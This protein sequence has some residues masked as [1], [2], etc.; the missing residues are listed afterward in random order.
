MIKESLPIWNPTCASGANRNTIF[1]IQC[2]YRHDRHESV[3]SSGSAI[4]DTTKV[5]PVADF[6]WERAKRLGLT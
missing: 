3:G 1:S 5:Y 2:E 4:G 6:V